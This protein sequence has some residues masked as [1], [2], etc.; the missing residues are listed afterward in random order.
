[1]KNDRLERGALNLEEIQAKLNKSIRLH[2][3]HA[4]A[5]KKHKTKFSKK[6]IAAYAR[7]VG[8]WQWRERTYFNQF[9]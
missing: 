8:Y 5:A 4:E 1:M 7:L 6:V 3:A 2:K 9:Y